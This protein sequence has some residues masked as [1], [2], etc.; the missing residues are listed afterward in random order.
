MCRQRKKEKREIRSLSSRARESSILKLLARAGSKNFRKTMDD[1][2]AYPVMI[3]LA[4]KLRGE[5]INFD[6]SFA[7]TARVGI[8]EQIKY[9]SLG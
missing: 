2:F 5:K 3:E 8:Y 4:T 1:R 9:G 6:L 7:S